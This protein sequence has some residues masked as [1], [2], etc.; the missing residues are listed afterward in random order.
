MTAGAL[1]RIREIVAI[2]KTLPREQHDETLTNACVIASK[3]RDTTETRIG[4]ELER[5][6]ERVVATR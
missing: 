2:D 5:G 1:A 3:V 6:R 4:D